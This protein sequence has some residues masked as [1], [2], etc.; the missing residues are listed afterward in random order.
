MV[1][2]GGGWGASFVGIR[3]RRRSQNRAW[4]RD[5]DRETELTGLLLTV[6]PAVVRRRSAVLQVASRAAMIVTGAG[7]CRGP[8]A[9][10]LGSTPKLA[11][12]LRGFGGVQAEGFHA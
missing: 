10:K 2:G 3:N 1:I 7:R 9:R 6:Q 4:D 8:R 11:V 12:K 5:R